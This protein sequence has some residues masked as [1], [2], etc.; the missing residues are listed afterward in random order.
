M[1][2]KSHCSNNCWVWHCKPWKTLKISILWGL[3]IAKGN[4]GNLSTVH[5]P[6]LNRI[7]VECIQTTTHGA[8]KVS[9]RKNQNNMRSTLSEMPR[10]CSWCLNFCRSASEL[11]GCCIIFRLRNR[12]ILRNPVRLLISPFITL[13]WISAVELGGFGGHPTMST[14]PCFFLQS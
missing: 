3:K 6:N 14:I 7:Y 9:T 2:A 5:P 1:M 11:H 4:S 8:R 10:H 12:A 13:L